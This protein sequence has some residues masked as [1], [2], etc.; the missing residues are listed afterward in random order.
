S[1]KKRLLEIVQKCL[2]NGIVGVNEPVEYPICPD[3]GNPSRYFKQQVIDDE[4][5]PI[6]ITSCP[7][8]GWIQGMGMHR[9][10]QPLD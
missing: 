4:G 7:A 3:C 5:Y 2:K 6:V 9:K 8:C 10:Q 1:S